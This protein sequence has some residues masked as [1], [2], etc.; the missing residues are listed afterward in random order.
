VTEGLNRLNVLIPSTIGNEVGED[1]T[2]INIGGNFNQSEQIID[3]V[4]D[5]S[6]LVLNLTAATTVHLDPYPKDGQRFAIVDAAQNLATYNLT[7]NANG[8]TF[9]SS[10]TGTLNTNGLSRSW[11]YRADLGDW[12]C[13]VTLATTDQLPFPS[14]FDDYFVIMLAMRL[15]PRYHQAIAPE[16]TEA[17]KRSRSQLR[18]RYNKPHLIEP[19]LDTRNFM[20][21]RYTSFSNRDFDTGRPR[22]LYW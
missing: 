7:I 5:D 18:A 8:R 1:F 20:T 19:D 11:L 14:D 4:P 17:L 2:D 13:I 22:S 16:T 9:E 6:R 12:V 15:N 21:R 10:A 3:W